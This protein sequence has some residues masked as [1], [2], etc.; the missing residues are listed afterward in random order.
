MHVFERGK[1]KAKPVLLLLVVSNPYSWRSILFFGM[2]L[3]LFSAQS[4]GETP[5]ARPPEVNE[6]DCKTAQVIDFGLARAREW[7]PR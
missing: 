7:K 1:L 3:L 6:L 5:R 2:L 4:R